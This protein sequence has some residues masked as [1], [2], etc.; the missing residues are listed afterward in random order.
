[1]AGNG[2]YGSFG[3]F[4]PGSSVHR[5]ALGEAVAFYIGHFYGRIGMGGEEGEWV[6]NFIPA[7]LLWDLDDTD[8]DFVRDPNTGIGGWDIISGFTPAMFFDALTPQTV[9]I[10]LFRDRLRT[11]HLSSTPNT[12]EDSNTFVDIYDVFNN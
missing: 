10:R 8:V 9:S 5:V 2:V 7:G 12:A 3:N 1:M 4:A 6:D 11:L